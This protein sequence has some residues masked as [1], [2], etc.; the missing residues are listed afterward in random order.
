MFES[1]R[2]AFRQAIDNFKTE[3]HRDDVPEA[4]DRLL[5]AMRREL[6]VAQETLDTLKAEVSELRREASEEG[7]HVRTCLRREEM[8]L[9][10]GDEET[11]RLAREYA[12]RHL[13]KHDLLIRKAEVA[14]QELDERALE[15]S[16][17]RS[18]FRSARARRSAL[19]AEA[20]RSDVRET[21]RSADALMAE[22]DRMEARVADA[23]LELDAAR[24]VEES[25]GGSRAPRAGDSPDRDLDRRLDQL[26]RQLMEE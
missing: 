15:M 16:E 3:L 26:K 6:A 21:L 4:A 8:A 1:L 7:Q 12:G 10:I 14:S 9:R 11:A 17:M 13:R 2:D 19:L 18:R 5:R 23:E 22:V 20:V 25:L 24:E